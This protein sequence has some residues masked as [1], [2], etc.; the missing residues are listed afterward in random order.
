MP[1]SLSEG[2]ADGD[3]YQGSTMITV[4]LARVAAQWR[5][6]FSDETVERV[7]AAMERSVRVHLRAIRLARDEVQRRC[8]GVTLDTAQTEVRVGRRGTVLHVDVDMD[9]PFLAEAV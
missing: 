3:R 6:P 9:V 1:R 5:E 8:P 4:D 2:A 7:F